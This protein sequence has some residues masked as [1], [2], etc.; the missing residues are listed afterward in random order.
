MDDKNQQ[1]ASND[2]GGKGYNLTL[3]PKAGTIDTTPTASGTKKTKFRATFEQR[4]KTVERTV[5]AMGKAAEAIEGKIVEGEAV[6]IRCLF[7]RAPAQEEGKRGA[8]YLTVLGLPLP[9]K[10]KAA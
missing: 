3:T 4:G 10:Q 7:D 8:E 6:A 5:V 1:N 2:N 9:P